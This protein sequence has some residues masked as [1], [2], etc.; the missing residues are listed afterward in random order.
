QDAFQCC[1]A[2]DGVGPHLLAQLLLGDHAVAMGEEIMEHLKHF[3]PQRDGLPRPL[4][5]IEL[6]IQRTV[7]EDIPHTEVS[8]NS[9]VSRASA[10]RG[11]ISP[12]RATRAG[13]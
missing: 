11:E 12:W 10:P 13:A 3:A 6:R 4:H 2:D 8:S 9:A 7:P 1:I 5:D